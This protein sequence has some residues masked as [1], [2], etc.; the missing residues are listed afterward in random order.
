MSEVK[1]LARQLQGL[2]KELQVY[3]RSLEY[4]YSAYLE[5]KEY[6]FARKLDLIALRS[7]ADVFK[8]FLMSNSKYFLPEELGEGWK[9]LFEIELRS[10]R[11]LEKL[12]LGQEINENFAEIIEKLKK[13]FNE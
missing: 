13:I 8:E 7:T 2:E 12:E 11:A 6:K 5:D 10:S 3:L 4:F 9:L 1:R